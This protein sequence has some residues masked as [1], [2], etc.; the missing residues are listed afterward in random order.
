MFRGG[1]LAAESISGVLEKHS[2]DIR[3]F[4]SILDFGCG[5]GRVI[6]HWA[7]LDA[8]VHG[9]DYNPR[10]I[11]WC[12]RHFPFARFEVNALSPPLPYGA[13]QFDLVYALSVFTH[14]P[15]SLALAWM[16]EMERVLNVG[17]WLIVTTHGESCLGDLT[18][19]QQSQVRRGRAVVKDEGSAGT[20]RC[21]VY[22][23][24][25]YV[26]RHLAERFQVVDFLP[27]GAKGNPPQDLALLQ[28]RSP[29]ASHDRPG[30]P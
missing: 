15:E 11:E 17:G 22:V 27:R 24:E 2:I 9:C 29:A 4:A 20:N 7:R 5:C 25:E 30:A 28:R 12:R 14:L 18:P 13:G 26:R 16:R 10:A 21:G 23:S 8:A 19:E 6:R 3:S 1:A